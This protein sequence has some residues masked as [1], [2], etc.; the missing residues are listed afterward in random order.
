M[1]ASGSVDRWGLVAERAVSSVER[2]DVS[3]APRLAGR[4]EGELGAVVTTQHS[5]VAT[6]RCEAVEFVDQ[7]VAGD[8]A[9]DQAA[10]VPGSEVSPGDLLQRGLL[11]LGVGK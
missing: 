2:L 3:V 7:G 9:F 8:V 1:D 11:Q 5:R 6:H 10:G 4:D